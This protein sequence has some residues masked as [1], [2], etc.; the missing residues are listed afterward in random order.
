MS[1]PIVS[2]L[3]CC[4]GLLTAHPMHTSVTELDHDP[5]TRRLT[6]VVRVFADDFTAA[7]G[8]ASDSLAAGYLRPRLELI[9]RTGRPI[10]LHW[11]RLEHAGDALL[12]H[13]R[14]TAPAGLTGARLR[15]AVLCERFS[16]QVNVVRIREGRRVASLLFVPGDEAKEL[17]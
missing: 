6:V 15:Q 8:G 1:A 9:D 14:G 10:A 12:L 5:A 4:A 3:L 7:T 13:L 16:D 11:E 2:A 17:P